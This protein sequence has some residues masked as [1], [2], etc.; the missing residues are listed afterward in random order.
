MVN[1]AFSALNRNLGLVLIPVLLDLVFFILGMMA[2]GF[3]GDAQLSIKVILDVGLPSISAILEH[4]ILAGSLVGA[5]SPV[6]FLFILSL[7]MGAFAEAGFVGLLYEIAREKVPALGSFVSYG[8]RFWLRFLGLRLLVAAVSI[9]GLLLAMLLSIVGLI[10]YMIIFIILRIKYIYWEFTMLSEDMGITDAFRRSRM[11]YDSRTPE[12]SKVII[13]ILVAN[14]L[15]A[16]VV[17]A[18]WSPTIVVIF[19]PIYCYV[20]SALQ[21]ALMTN[22]LELGVEPHWTT[23]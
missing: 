14:F 22:K 16:V 5:D 2:T 3:W 18:L 1:R 13:A 23:D 10:A 15:L 8:K 12:L 17:N 19:I 9:A 4:D 11:L 6:V 21:L 20:A 7:L